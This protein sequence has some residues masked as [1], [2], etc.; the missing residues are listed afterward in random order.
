[1]QTEDRVNIGKEAGCK[2][3]IEVV[4]WMAR[5]GAPWRYLP[6]VQP[7]LFIKGCNNNI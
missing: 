5:S 1:M 3:F 6:E 4:L 7:F 2:R